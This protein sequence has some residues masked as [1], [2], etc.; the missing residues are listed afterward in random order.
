MIIPDEVARLEREHGWTSPLLATNS[1][2]LYTIGSTGASSA[3]DIAQMN[4]LDEGEGGWWY[5][6][7][8]Q[9]LRAV[10]RRFPIEGV[11]WDVGSGSG[12]VTKYLVDQG[13]RTIGIEPNLRGAQLSAQRGVPSIH[14]VLAE[15]SLPDNSLAGIGMFDVL[16]HLADRQEVLREVHRV[17]RPGGRLFL[18]LPALMALWS[19][20]DEL[21]GHQLRYSR[22]SIKREVEEIGLRIELNRYFFLTALPI[23]F[24]VRVVPYR[25]GRRPLISKEKMVSSGGGLVG[26]IATAVEL[27]WS[28]VGLIGTSLL[29]VARKP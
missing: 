24:L 4:I 18:T 20:Y 23:L 19:T 26:R 9:V 2:G 29:V 12:L 17:L 25:F 10:L 21:D 15:L 3:Y 11:L 13:E 6:T 22:K 1:V 5:D 7:R 8:N 27:L 28:K 14:G 16:E